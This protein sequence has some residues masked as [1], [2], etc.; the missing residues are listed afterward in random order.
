MSEEHRVARKAGQVGL[1]TLASRVLGLAREQV[2]A[3][4]FGAGFATDAFNVAFRIPNLLRDLFAEGAMS[5]AFVPTFTAVYEKEGET[6]AWAFG[7]QLMSSL[8]F[9]LAAVCVIGWLTAPWL[10]RAFAPGFGA[11]PGKLELTVQL[12]RV[13][14][15][16][17]APMVALPPRRRW[18]C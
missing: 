3:G 12:T 1:A 9:V 18:G 2:M 8:L 16:V 7:R 15:A 5:S 10:V 17:P 6:A 13:D 11:I 14:A 4:L